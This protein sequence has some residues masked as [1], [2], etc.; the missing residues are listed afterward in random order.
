M[1]NR[2][3]NSWK[4]PKIVQN[5]LLPRTWFVL[6]FHIFCPSLTHVL[7]GFCVKSMCSHIY[8]VGFVRRCKTTV[9]ARKGIPGICIYAGENNILLTSCI[10][11]WI[12]PYLVYIYAVYS[13]TLPF[14]TY[15]EVYF[16]PDYLRFC[17]HIVFRLFSHISCSC[18]VIVLWFV[19]VFDSDFCCQIPGTTQQFHLVRFPT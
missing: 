6:K 7:G 17:F 15:F 16:F 14:M 3:R 11:L 10:V 1:Q 5:V 4:Y 9:E 12:A 8:G 19:S 13:P 18:F 2:P